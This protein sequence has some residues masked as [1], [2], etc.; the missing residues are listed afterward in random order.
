MNDSEACHS[1]MSSKIDDDHT[2]DLIYSYLILLALIFIQFTYIRVFKS[3]SFF[4]SQNA[5]PPVHCS[6][7]WADTC[8]Q[9]PVIN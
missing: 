3:F 9:N 2:E 8:Q 4:C 5:Q 7:Q 6:Y 1:F